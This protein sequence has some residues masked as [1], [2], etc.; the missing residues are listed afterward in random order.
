MVEYSVAR[1]KITDKN[2]AELLWQ[3]TAKE[4]SKIFS[5][6]TDFD[7]LEDEFYKCMNEE[8]A[9]IKRYVENNTGEFGTI[10]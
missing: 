1:S 3:K 8:T 4:I 2:E 9:V 5:S 7:P 6:I 10:V